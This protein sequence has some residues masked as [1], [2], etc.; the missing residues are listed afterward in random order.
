MLHGLFRVRDFTQDDAH[1]YCTPEQ[2]EDE[3]LGVMRFMLHIYAAFGFTDVQHRALDPAGKE[4]RHRTRC[5]RPPRAPC[6]HVLEDEAIDYKINPGDGAFYGPKIDFHIRDVM[7]RT[8][9]C[10]TIQ[11]DFAM[12]ERFDMT[13]IGDDNEEHRPVMIHR[14]MLG[15]HRALHGHPDRALRRQLAVWLAPVQVRVLP[16]SDRHADYA[17]GVMRERCA[18]RRPAGRVDDRSESWGRGSATANSQKVPYLLVVGDREE[19]AGAVSVRERGEEKGSRADRQFVERELAEVRRSGGCRRSRPRLS[20]ARSSATTPRRDR[21]AARSASS[22]ARSNGS[23][24]VFAARSPMACPAIP[25]L[26]AGSQPSTSAFGTMRSSQDGSRHARA[27]SSDITAG[28][29]VMRTMNAS[30]RMPKAKAKPIVLMIGI[31]LQGEAAEDAD[32]DDGGGQRRLARRDE[33]R[34]AMASFGESPRM[35]SSLDACP[36]ED[37]VVHRQTEEDADQEDRR[38]GDDRAGAVLTPSAPRSHPHWKTATTAP[39]VARTLSRKP[40]TAL[41]GTSRLRNMMVS[42]TNARPTMTARYGIRGAAQLGR[43]IDRY[44]RLACDV[45]LCSSRSLAKRGE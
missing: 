44:R 4:H 14:A 35:C 28:P 38:E 27:P 41:S 25:A 2:I 26:R 31:R 7:G 8:W 40:T 5:G 19:Q 17:A 22:L 21:A 18:V 16:I 10:G 3:M 43:D 42:S 29:N 11:L 45:G 23:L 6:S 33:S 13:Y 20:R 37:L 9:Q 15:S 1:I 36:Q 32:H 39:N 30:T 34:C 24:G 12:P